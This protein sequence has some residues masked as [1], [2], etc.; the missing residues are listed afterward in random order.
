[1]LFSFGKYIYFSKISIYI[2]LFSSDWNL[3][4]MHKACKILPDAYFQMI[5]PNLVK[6]PKIVSYTYCS[7]NPLIVFIFYFCLTY[8]ITVYHGKNIKSYF[9]FTNLIQSIANNLIH[10]IHFSIE[11]RIYIIFFRR[12]SEMRFCPKNKL[13]RSLDSIECEV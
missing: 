1:M 2:S 11:K 12:K 9:H 7:S 3:V 4:R 10:P 13:D 8:I 5:K 6:Y